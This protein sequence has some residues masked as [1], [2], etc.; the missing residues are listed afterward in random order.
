MKKTAKKLVAGMKLGW[1]LGNTLDS[2]EDSID[3]NSKPEAWETAWGNPVTSKELIEKIIDE[4]FHVIRFPVSWRNHINDEA[5]YHIDEAWMN[6]V[7]ELVDYAYEHGACVILNIHHEGWHDPYYEIQDAAEK[8]LRRVWEQIADCF[9]DYGE[10]LIFEGMNEPRKRDTPFEWNGGDEEGWNVVNHLNRAF[11]DTIR[12][13]GG[14]NPDRCLMIPGYAANCSV[15]IRHLE[16]PEG[17][18]NL[19]VSVHAYEPY[20]FALNINGRGLW[21]EDTKAIDTLMEDLEELFLSRDI[22]V[23]IGEFG[24]MH[25]PV[26]GNEASR[27]Q[28]AEYYVRTAKEHGVPCVWWDNGLFEGEGELF[29]LINRQ[30]LEWKYPK[31]V[32]GLKK[33]LE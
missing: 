26:E 19:I 15:G 22:P 31:V 11:I 32:A 25:K 8:K 13:S 24:A 33:G 16:V 12:H 2:F 3:K 18:D 30:T 4:G 20:D 23:I 10:R 7:K 21:E 29:G 17:D 27:G 28:W 5:N 6:R 14:N 1:S 9:K